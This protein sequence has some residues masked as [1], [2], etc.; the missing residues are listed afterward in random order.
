MTTTAADPLAAPRAGRFWLLKRTWPIARV[1]ITG[2]VPC[3]DLPARRRMRREALSLV[4]LRTWPGMSATSEDVAQLAMLRL[5]HLQKKVHRLVLLR[6]REAS[7]MM[8]RSGVETLLLGLYCM[9]VPGAVGRLHAG[10]VKALGDTLAYLEE[11]GIAPASVIREC[12]RALGEPA[13]SHLSPWDMVQAIDDA[14]DNTAAR[15]IYRRLYLSLS[16]F[17]VHA[18]GGTLLRHVSKR[19]DLRRRPARAWTRRSPARVID[20][21]AGTLAADLARHAGRPDARLVRYAAKHEA[22]TIMPI[23]VMAFNGTAG[24]SSN[25]FSRRRIIEAARIIKEVYAYLWT[26]PAAADPVPVRK[27]FVRERFAAIVSSDDPEIPSA[28]LA[29]LIEHVAAT[30][31]QPQSAPEPAQPASET[32]DRNSQHLSGID[33]RTRAHD[34][35]PSITGVPEPRQNRRLQPRPSTTILIAECDSMSRS[36]WRRAPTLFRGNGHTSGLC[37]ERRASNS[38]SRSSGRRFRPRGRGCRATAK[39]KWPVK[40]LPLFEGTCRRQL[41]PGC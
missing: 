31:A 28:A 22:R 37:A 34:K 35:P 17:T 24:S 4:S 41:S 5:L 25:A 3:P 11:T 18:S 16:H 27:A 38:A 20:A 10:N 23:V 14:N 32:A 36:A 6:Q 40:L 21:A 39:E 9:R 29:P 12:A 1:A 2:F 19:G 26:G 13:R 15:S 33:L 30:L 8:A 7:V